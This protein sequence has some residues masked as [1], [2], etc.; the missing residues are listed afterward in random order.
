MKNVTLLLLTAVLF[1]F[2]ACDRKKQEEHKTE[3]AVIKGV[4]SNS[5]NATQRVG[6]DTGP[7]GLSEE[8]KYTFV[9]SDMHD[10]NHTFHIEHKHITL[11]GV[12]KPIVLLHFFA[13]WCPPCQ[14]EAPYLADLQKKYDKELFVLGLLVN[15]SPSDANLTAFRKAYGVN[16]FISNTKENAAVHALATEK[17]QL[18]ADHPLPLTILFKKGHYYSHYE[19]AVP[20]EMLEYDINNARHKE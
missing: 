19:G 5:S 4:E 10:H 7:K 3:T 18:P 6:T 2:T 13:T 12:E 11:S 8:E 1:F 15:D 14:G 16:Y 20:V 9:L 17:L